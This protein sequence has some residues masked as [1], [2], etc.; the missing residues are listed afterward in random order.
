M[1]NTSMFFYLPIYCSLCKWSTSFSSGATVSNKHKRKITAASAEPARHSHTLL[2]LPL[3][4]HTAAPGMPLPP[5]ISQKHLFT[6]IV[7]L[8]L[9]KKHK[10]NQLHWGAKTGQEAIN[11]SRHVTPPGTSSCPH[12]DPPLWFVLAEI[13]PL[14]STIPG[15]HNLFQC[16]DLLRK[17]GCKSPY[18]KLNPRKANHF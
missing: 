18:I 1:E 15:V 16:A 6:P 9:L 17:M 14:P 4:G 10:W 3:K 12:N 8:H 5:K 13:P 7:T 11:K 2:S